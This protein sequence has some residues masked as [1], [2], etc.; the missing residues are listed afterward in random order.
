MHAPV[1]SSTRSLTDQS[2]V[3]LLNKFCIQLTS[4]FRD[5]KTQHGDPSAL[6]VHRLVGQLI[7]E[8]RARPGAEVQSL[9]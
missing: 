2:R 1:S 3:R 7:G 5:A 8:H 4:Q 9:V 6:Q